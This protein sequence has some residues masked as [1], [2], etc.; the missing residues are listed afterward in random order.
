MPPV[1]I[2]AERH[3]WSF[4]SGLLPDDRRHPRSPKHVVVSGLGAWRTPEGPQSDTPGGLIIQGPRVVARRERI[5]EWAGAPPTE[6]EWEYA[7]GGL[8]GQLFPWGNDAE[9]GPA[10][11][12]RAAGRSHR[13]HPADGYWLRRHRAR[14][15][16][17]GPQPHRQRLGMVRR[18]VT[19]YTGVA[20][21][22]PPGRGGDVESCGAVDW[23]RLRR[24]Y[25][26]A[27]RERS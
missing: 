6:A 13:E 22:E 23:P 8:V 5:A 17:M 19:R 15:T 18:L 14:P 21:R 2:D 10:P 24:R 9:P 26:A 12:E 11:H 1:V 3:E 25:G 16:A 7:R 20:G 27:Q 4:V